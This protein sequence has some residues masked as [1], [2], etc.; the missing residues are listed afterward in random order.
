MDLEVKKIGAPNA[1][2]K[3]KKEAGGL[4]G[5]HGSSIVLRTA[6]ERDLKTEGYGVLSRAGWLLLLVA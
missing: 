5:A 1:K 2:K 6:R 4:R 3:K